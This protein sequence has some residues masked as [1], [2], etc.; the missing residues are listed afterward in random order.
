[1]LDQ[2]IFSKVIEV[3]NAKNFS[4]G[5]IKDFKKARQVKTKKVVLFDDFHSMLN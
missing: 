4:E 3:T 1:M 2:F 5:G